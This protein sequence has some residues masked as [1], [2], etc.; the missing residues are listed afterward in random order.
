MASYSSGDIVQCSPGDPA[1]RWRTDSQTGKLPPPDSRAPALRVSTSTLPVAWSVNWASTSTELQAQSL[2]MSHSPIGLSRHIRQGGMP[3]KIGRE[4]LW[5]LITRCDPAGAL[6]TLETHFV[7]NHAD[8]PTVRSR[9][10][11]EEGPLRSAFL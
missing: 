4:L 11:H 1:G 10:P 7:S 6:C 9:C 2:K 8:T 5:I 3:H